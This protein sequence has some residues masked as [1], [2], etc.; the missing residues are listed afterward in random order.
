MKPHDTSEFHPHG[1]ATHTSLA[2]L[3]RW[4]PRIT[5]LIGLTSLLLATAKWH[6]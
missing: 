1:A 3:M 6:P 2:H 4:L 5:V